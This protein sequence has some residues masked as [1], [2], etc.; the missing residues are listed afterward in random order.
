MQSTV[1][2]ALKQAKGLSSWKEGKKLVGVSQLLVFLLPAKLSQGVDPGRQPMLREP[3]F[4][5]SL[6]PSMLGGR[7]RKG[8][9][10][11]HLLINEELSRATAL[12]L[13]NWASLVSLHRAG[14]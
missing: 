1:P 12:W 7:E 2:Q 4:C 14:T 10:H 6:G 9:H 5:I 13:R 8:W 3:M 11:L